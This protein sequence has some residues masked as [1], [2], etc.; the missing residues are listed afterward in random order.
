MQLQMEIIFS[1]G[2][3]LNNRILL[4]ES[5]KKKKNFF[6]L[7]ASKQ[8]N[9]C[10]EKTYVVLLNNPRIFI[11]VLQKNNKQNPEAPNK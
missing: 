6:S 2:Q 5:K 9:L 10:I 11:S 3:S 8:K 4:K 1:D 7:K